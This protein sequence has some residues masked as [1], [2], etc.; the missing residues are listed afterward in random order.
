[1]NNLLF[2]YGTLLNDDNEFGNYLRKNS[3]VYSTGKVK[4]SLYDIGE[5]PG[6]VLSDGD[7]YV[8]GTIFQLNDPVSALKI[9]DEYEGFG[10]DQP[11]PNEYVRVLTEVETETDIIICWIYVYNLPVDTFPYINSGK[12]PS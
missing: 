9:L 5:Y 3:I 10:E 4:G 1:M 7:E 11:Q 12:Y 2:V 6:V 8:Y